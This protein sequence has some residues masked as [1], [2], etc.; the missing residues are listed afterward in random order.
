[1]RAGVTPERRSA[2]RYTIE[3]VLQY[4]RS[5]K[6]SVSERGKTVDISSGGVRFTTAS[7]LNRGDTV[8]LS[9]NW[10][11]LLGG[12]CPLKLQML[13]YVV[14]TAPETAV[15]KIVRYEFRTRREK[16]DEPATMSLRSQPPEVSFGR[17][18]WLSGSSN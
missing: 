2:R 17:R 3:Q 11:A 16:I 12:G 10:P 18:S 9:M 15:V 14:R 1:M 8:E 13:G 4:K 6:G 7:P 5:C